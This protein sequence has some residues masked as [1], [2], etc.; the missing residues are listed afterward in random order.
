MF[1]FQ[2]CVAVTIDGGKAQQRQVDILMVLMG[3]LLEKNTPARIS[4]GAYY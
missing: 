4:Y 2:I 1:R 3:G